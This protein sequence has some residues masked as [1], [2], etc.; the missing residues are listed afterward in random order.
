[1]GDFLESRRRLKR[2]FEGTFRVSDIAETLAS[3]DAERPAADVLAVLERRLYKAGGVRERGRVTGYV[4]T[5][6]LRG[7][8]GTYGEAAREF[9]DDEVISGD[10]GL[11][12]AIAKLGE[13]PRLFVRSLGGVAG[14]VTRT[15]LQKPPVRMWLFGVITMIELTFSR[16]I[17][18]WYPDDAWTRKMSAGRLRKAETLL[19]ERRRRAEAGSLRLLD[20][21]QLSDKGQI[22]AKDEDARRILGFRSKRHADEVV[23]RLESL[24]NSLAHS[25]DIVTEGWEFITNMADQIDDIVR[26]GA[27]F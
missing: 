13:R 8:D 7:H 18:S 9:E 15:D 23:K 27:T 20:C 1:M 3:F 12:E 26:I 4:L 10:A 11:S 19:A 21:L 24:R 25:Q 17:E 16:M 5:D 14:I 2:F 22:L 6:E